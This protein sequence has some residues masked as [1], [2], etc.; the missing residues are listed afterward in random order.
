MLVAALSPPCIPKSIT[1]VWVGDPTRRW[2]MKKLGQKTVVLG[3]RSAATNLNC[4][5][6]GG[7]EGGQD[8]GCAC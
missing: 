5:S 2:V 6:R 7:R 3:V 4:L 1:Q 8:R